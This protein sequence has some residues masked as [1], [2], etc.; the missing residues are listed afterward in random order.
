MILWKCTSQAH[1]FDNFFGNFLKNCLIQI[2][3]IFV[4]HSKTPK[5][6]IMHVKPHRSSHWHT[7]EHYALLN[8]TIDINLSVNYGAMLS[9]AN[10]LSKI[11]LIPITVKNNII[12]RT[13]KKRIF[14]YSFK[15]HN[16]WGWKHR[17]F[18]MAI[19]KI[20]HKLNIIAYGSLSEFW[21]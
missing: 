19:I 1:V 17:S 2:K 21:F 12:M 4:Y 3:K 6:S 15:V 10:D 5:Q 8:C 13:K 20:I 16:V 7:T 9:S 18:F 14:Y 11:Q